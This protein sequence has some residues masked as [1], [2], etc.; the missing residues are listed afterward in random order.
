MSEEVRERTEC[1]ISSPEQLHDYIHVTS[2]SL[3]ILLIMIIVILG[4]MIILAATITIET[5]MDVQ[6][7]VT[8][9]AS[10]GG[11]FM[12]MSSITGERRNQVKIGMEVRIAGEKGSITELID[13]EQEVFVVAEPD[14][15]GANLMEGIY[16][17]VIVLERT[18]PISFLLEKQ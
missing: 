18:T 5:T 16:E 14:R 2:P 11:G 15:A 10:E 13:N 12:L 6:M 8:D 4:A 9:T 17:A 1:R 3:W 7:E